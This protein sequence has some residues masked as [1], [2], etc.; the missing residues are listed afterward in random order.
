MPSTRYL[1][2]ETDERGKGVARCANCGDISPI[3]ISP[4]EEFRPIGKQGRACC[5]ATSYQPLS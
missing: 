2:S 3:E 4:S 1:M 5:T